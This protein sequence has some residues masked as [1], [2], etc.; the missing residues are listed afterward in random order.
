MHGG[1]GMDGVGAP[2]LLGGDIAQAYIPHLA[3]LGLAGHGADCLLD[4]HFR[5]GVVGVVEVDVVGAEAFQAVVQALAGVIRRAVDVEGEAP[6]GLDGVA[7]LTLVEDDAELGGD[8]GLVTPALYGFGDELFVVAVAV[9]VGAV[10]HRALFDDM[11][12]HL[13]ALRLID[14]SVEALEHHR[15]ISDARDGV[16]RLGLHRV[17]HRLAP[18]WAV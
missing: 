12:Q 6:A 9:G 2:Q 7:G 8:E 11:A 3:G 10:D 15:A 1:D 17:F 18:W 14:A 13:N 5:V 16:A 4:S